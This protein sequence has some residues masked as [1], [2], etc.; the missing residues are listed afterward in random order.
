[1]QTNT[2]ATLYVKS[3]S[4]GEESWTRQA[5]SAVFWENRKA[6]NVIQSG[7]LQAD[8]V[9]VYIP[10]SVG[11]FTI[12]PGDVLVKG[13]A[14]D[15]ISASFT[16]TDLK[17]AYSDVITVKSVDTMDYGSSHMQHL[18]IGGS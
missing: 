9:A 7:M 1:M 4:S 18:Q 14:T 2:A 13:L 12:K 6:A 8:K 16:I 5:I 17:K 11:S 3:V 15:E 10:F